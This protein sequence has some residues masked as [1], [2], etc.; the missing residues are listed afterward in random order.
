MFSLIYPSTPVPVL[1]R[2]SALSPNL[3]EIPAG[4]E[5]LPVIE[6][7]GWVIGQATRA[8]CHKEGL[9]HPVIHLHIIRRTGEMFL[10]KRSSSKDT[11]PGYWDTAV[12]GHVS[13]GESLEAALFRET[14]EELGLTGFNPVFLGTDLFEGR[15]EREWVT[16]FGTVGNFSLHPSNDEV[17]EG[18]WWKMQEIEDNLGK[19]VFTPNFEQEFGKVRPSL[20]ALL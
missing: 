15:T 11:W 18:R 2:P 17:S 4:E 14:E 13:F 19:S 16:L 20:E 12:G 1:P 6:E 3:P 5:M 8:W 9:L 7:T 10:Q